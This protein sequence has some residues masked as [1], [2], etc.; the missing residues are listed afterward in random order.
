MPIRQFLGDKRP[1]SPED[2][3]IMGKA[4]TAAV[5][6]LGLPSKDPMIDTRIGS[7]N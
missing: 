4:L 3:D 2:L 6:K 1:F 7:N 5:A